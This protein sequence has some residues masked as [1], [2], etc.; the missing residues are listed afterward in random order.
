MFPLEPVGL[1]IGDNKM[2]SNTGEQICFGAHRQLAKDFFNIRKILSHSQFKSINWVSIYQMLHDLP[3]LFQTWAAKHVLR[4]V[5]TIK[6]LAHQDGRSPLCPSCQECSKTCTHIACCPKIRRAAAFAQSTQGVEQWLEQQNTH[7]NLQS[8][9]LKYL[10]GRGSM[11]C[12]EC[13]LALNL[14]HII[15]EFAKSQDVIGWDNFAAGMVS[16]KL[17]LIQ[18]LH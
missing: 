17:L 16:N 3:R 1:F 5:G 6:F 11:T 18:S 13:S 14:P 2:T 7:S 15:Q 4:I 8:L 9:I 10:Q 12:Y